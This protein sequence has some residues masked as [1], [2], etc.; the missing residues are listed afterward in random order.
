M[1]HSSENW[2]YRYLNELIGT[3][4][5]VLLGDGA[6]VLNILTGGFGLFGVSILWGFAV[7]FAVYWVG[8]VS[9]G[10]INPA[11]TIANAAFR[12]FPWRRVPG[13]IA[14]QVVG[15]FLGAVWLL[16]IWSGYYDA[17]DAAHGVTRGAPGSSI[18][19]MTLWTFFPNPAFAGVTPEKPLTAVASLVSF[20]QAF[21]SQAM[22]TAVLVAVIFALTDDRNPMG[23]R[24]TA[25]L[26]AFLIGLLVAALVMYESPI[27]MAALNPARDFGPRVAGYLFGWGRIAFPGPRGGWWVPV[28]APLVGGLVGAFAYDYGTRVRLPP[29]DTGEESPRVHEPDVAEAEE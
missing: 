25:A 3:F 14:A 26:G 23:T 12:G 11:V 21:L 8:G 7:M 17:Y 9:E 20:P 5:L 18:T 2:G 22:V 10:H 13:Y 16:F 24:D 27:D 19:G 29:A 15:A 6:V 28:L 1:T 4:I